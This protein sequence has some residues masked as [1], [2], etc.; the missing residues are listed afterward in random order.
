MR[1]LSSVFEA[2]KKTVLSVYVTASYPDLE[3]TAQIVE[4]LD[5]AG[6]DFIELG[7]PFSDP[8]ADGE[9]IQKASEI[10]INNGF[11]IRKLTHQ[12]AEIRS[13]SD[14]PLVLMGYFNPIYK[15]GVENT[16]KF[17][18][19]YGIEAII[20]P[21]LPI[22]VYKKEYQVLFESYGIDFVFM[23]TPLTSKERILEIDRLSNSF[24]YLVSTSS[25]TGGKLDL[26]EDR[27]IDDL[28]RIKDMDLNNPVVVGFGIH[29]HQTFSLVNK[30][31]DGAI[32]GS[33]FIKALK[34]NNS[35]VEAFVK[36]IK[37]GI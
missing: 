7:M 34:Q 17:C 10:A 27:Y 20:I 30:Y 5:K 2:Q 23:I 16:L 32:V 25:V 4:K 11:K 12:L 22:E 13:K 15:F 19:N 8:L 14:I 31:F 3:S 1:K 29:D 18:Y 37:T 33:A 35:S 26:N 24:I 36:R 28:A 21:D 9:T 6:V